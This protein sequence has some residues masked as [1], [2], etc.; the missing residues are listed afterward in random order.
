MK[1][2]IMS[3]MVVLATCFSANA[4][5]QGKKWLV[6]EDAPS[7]IRGAHVDFPRLLL[8]QISKAGLFRCV[9]R[10]TYRTQAKELA[11]GDGGDVNF[12]AAGYCISWVVRTKDTARGKILTVS[13]GYNNI[14]KSGNNELLQSEDVLVY[15]RNLKG[16]D[17]LTAAA[18]KCAR[19]ILFRLM[20]PQIVEVKILKSGKTSATV[21]YGKDFLTIGDKV[22]FFRK[23]ALKNGKEISKQVGTGVVR[24]VDTDFSV[25]QL[26]KGAVAE[27]DNVSV[28]DAEAEAAKAG[29]CP[30]C[31][32][33][34]QIRIDVQC[35]G[36][37][38]QGKLWHIRG[39]RRTL[40]PCQECHGKG[41]RSMDKI[42]E[43]CHGAG[44]VN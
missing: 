15:E 6:I 43:E 16:E 1:K 23:K 3:I 32:G 7:N 44:K 35:A 38:G 24:S 27:D 42:C 31:D 18:K 20:P 34:K 2:L 26:L 30:V 14:G 39:R 5:R 21:D 13:V 28:V 22:N 17:L 9:D 41:T 25:L 37:N 40:Q 10:A 36:C 19:A 12:S 4:D 29:V 33:K 8:M 11:L